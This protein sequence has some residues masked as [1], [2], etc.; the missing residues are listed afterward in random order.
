M[1]HPKAYSVIFLVMVLL[2][3]VAALHYRSKQIYESFASPNMSAILM[4]KIEKDMKTEET[5]SKNIRMSFNKLQG[6]I[7]A[8]DRVIPAAKK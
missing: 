3:A 6:L 5:L 2:F 1:K 4:D 8:K 7:A